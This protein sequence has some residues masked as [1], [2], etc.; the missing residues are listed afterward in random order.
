MA[1]RAMG[2]TFSRIPVAWLGSM[3]IGRCVKALTTGTAVRSSVLRVYPSKVR[4]PRSHKMT[5]S[6]PSD[7]MYSADINHSSMVAAS[8]RLRSTGLPIRPTLLSSSKFCIF[9]AP[10]CTTSTYLTIRSAWLGEVISVTIPNPVS[11]RTSARILSPSSPRPWN[12]YGD[13][14]GLK[15]PPRNKTAP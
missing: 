4:I 13:V 2:L 14:L 8:P 10:I 9:R 3:M 7:K 11:A 5:W 1:A 6:F 15:A 12:A